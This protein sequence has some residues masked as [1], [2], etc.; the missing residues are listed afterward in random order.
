[1]NISWN[2]LSKYRNELY[3]I[4]ILWIV[5]FHGVILKKVEL[6][7]EL[8]VLTGILKHGNCGVEIFL[9]LSGISLYYSMKKEPNAKKFYVKRLKRIVIP[10]VLIE[11]TYWFY[12]CVILKNDFLEFVKNITL[13]SFWFEGEKL[14]WFVALILLL[15]IFYP[16]LFKFILNNS[17]INRIFFIVSLCLIVYVICGLLKYF[18][19]HCFKMIEIALTRIPVFLL[20]SYCGILAY[21]NKEIKSN[22]KLISFII[23]IMGIGYFYEQPFSL[24][25]NFRMPYLLLGPSLAIWIS[26]CLNSISNARL[27]R[28]LSLWGGLSLEVYLSHVIL[29]LKF[30][31]SVFYGKS[32]VANFHKYL[33]FVLLGAFV[34][35]KLV[36]YIQDKI[37][38]K[39]NYDNK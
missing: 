39:V 33:I 5:L 2:I 19:P 18:D 3:G 26:V 8:S 30:L 14:V 32:A 38:L 36:V 16:V 29:R 15:Y 9:F 20:G 6:S 4:S 34:I 21:E 1:M 28:L 10:L 11:G 17:K 13:Y 37:I 7:N 27:N 25:N 22:I 31:D 24:V 23:V 12:N 35:S